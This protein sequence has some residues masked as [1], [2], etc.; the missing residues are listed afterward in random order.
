M[1]RN[2]RL[3]RIKE[4]IGKE[5]IGTQEMLAEKLAVSGFKV[6]QATLSRDMRELGVVKKRG[7]NGRLIYSLPGEEEQASGATK[8]AAR[9]IESFVTGID[10]SG[11]LI[12]IKTMPGHA[13]GVAASIDRLALSGILG[14]IA[15]DD[16]IL[17]VT[18]NP[19]KGRTIVKGLE[20]M[21][22]GRKH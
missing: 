10:L 1:G 16:T 17:V 8:G 15:G 14:T 9:M 2:A 6:T 7:R 13:Q 22:A 11:N 12:V 5:D 3:E 20:D 19:K 18:E 21:L 4:I